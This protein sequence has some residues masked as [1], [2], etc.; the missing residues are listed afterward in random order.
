MSNELTDLVDS[1]ARL[2]N[3]STYV[4]ALVGAGLSVESG[5]PTFRGPGGLWERLGQPS[6]RG[7]QDF[8]EDPEGWWKHQLDLQVDPARTEFRDAIEKAKPNPGHYA[9]AQLEALGVLKLTIT[10]NVDDLH[11]KAGSKLVAEIHG[12][13]TKLRCIV[14]E[15]RWPRED[16]VIERYPPRCPECGG[17]VKGD[18]VMF[19]EPIP[20]G[21]LERCFAEAERCDCMILAGTSATVYPAARFPQTVRERGGLLIEAN[22][23]PTPLSGLSEVVLRAPTG[24]VFPGLVRRVKEL[25][26]L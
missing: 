4:V 18:T 17:L 7:Y 25:R 8:L 5:V 16:F 6:V 12:K 19:G 13:R 26:G 15:S 14:C 9:L 3:D 2:I 10:Q 1:A 20:P 11:F 23:N 22:P 24:E 21:V